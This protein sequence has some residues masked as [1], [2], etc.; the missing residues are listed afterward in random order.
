MERV[1]LKPKPKKERKQKPKPER[2]LFSRS[3]AA[4]VLGTSV[5]SVWRLEKEG[6]LKPIKLDPR[7][8]ATKT[9]YKANEV[10]RIAEGVSDAPG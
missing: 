2:V 1:T 7:R 4:H 10:Y 8:P 9:Y 3:D 5:A 6:R